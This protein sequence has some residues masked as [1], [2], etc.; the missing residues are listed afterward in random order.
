VWLIIIFVS[1]KSDH[2][3]WSFE[4]L[5]RIELENDSSQ[6]LSSLHRYPILIE[7]HK[8]LSIALLQNESLVGEMHT[9]TLTGE[10]SFCFSVNSLASMLS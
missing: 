2:F 6:S 4:V 5:L 1:V 10:A 7:L 9:N 8:P 3:N